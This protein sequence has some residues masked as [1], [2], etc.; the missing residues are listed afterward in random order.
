MLTN[1][2]IE[3]ANKIRAAMDNTIPE[4]KDKPS[5]I[6]KAMDMIRPW[7]PGA[8]AV[9]DVRMYEGIPY[10]CVQAHDSTGN[11]TWNPADTPALW[12]QYH[13]TSL[14]T[15]RAWVAPTGAH[16]M[17]KAGEYMVFTDG[18][19]YKC[20]TDTSYSPVYHIEAWEAV[21]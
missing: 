19:T 9:D 21:V 12:M 16:D 17:Y 1:A 15:A 14:E 3:R 4:I 11:G 20:L 10:K 5:A 2:Q 8:F 7:N 6:N 13:G 18:K